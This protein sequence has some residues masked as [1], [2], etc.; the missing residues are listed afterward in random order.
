MGLP[1]PKKYIPEIEK[2]RALSDS[3]T[4]ELV[5]ALENSPVMSR[6]E[7]MA[8]RIAEDV[9]SVSLDDLIGIADLIYALYQ[10]REYSEFGSSQFLKELVEGIGEHASPAITKEELAV[11]QDR[12]RRLLNI[13][14]LNSISKAISLQR[15]GEHLYCNAKI[16]SDIRPV[17][18]TDVSSLPVA[19]TIVHTLKL[20]YHERGEHKEFFILLDEAGL[21]KLQEVIERAQ[22]KSEALNELL[23]Q[24]KL[25][26]LGA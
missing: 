7:E 12:F 19:A 26:R 18:G 13:D 2:V 9:P 20:G 5:Q 24:A 8:A 23:K 17:F 25:P 11:I 22:D 21:V 16:V 15:D 10:V 3:T 6:S 1:I 14:T 4:D